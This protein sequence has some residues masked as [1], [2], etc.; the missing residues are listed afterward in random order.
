M[1]ERSE[2]D[3][4]H[5]SVDETVLRRIDDASRTVDSPYADVETLARKVESVSEFLVDVARERALTDY[6]TVASECGSTPPRLERVLVVLGVHEAANDRPLRPRSSRGPTGRYRARRTSGWSN[7]CRTTPAGSP[8]TPEIRE[9][10]WGPTG[11]RCIGGGPSDRAT[12]TA[13]RADGEDT[14]ATDR[15]ATR[16]LASPHTPSHVHAVEPL[17]LPKKTNQNIQMQKT[18]SQ[19]PY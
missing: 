2:R 19:A 18:V 15:R 9:W 5:P 6:G 3:A 12:A 14:P 17:Q 16:R 8:Q 13:S 11:R 10:I 7:R 4:L 1:L